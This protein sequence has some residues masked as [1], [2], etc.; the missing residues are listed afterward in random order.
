[1][2]TIEITETPEE[3]NSISILNKKEASL[4]QLA[5]DYADL[6]INGVSDKEGYKK[7][8]DA[9]IILKNTRIQIKKVA[10]D[11]REDAKNFQKKVIAKEN[12]LIGLIS[13]TEEA[14]EAE[15]KRIDSEKEAIKKE[16]ERKKA[17]KI[18]NRINSLA[19][20]NYA[21]DFSEV[22]TMSNEHFDSLLSHANKEFQKEQ[23]RIAEEKAE[24]ERKKAEQEELLAKQR[25]EIAE[26]KAKQEEIAREQADREAK[27]KKEQEEAQRK[28]EEQVREFNLI[29][30]EQ[31]AERDRIQAEKQAILDQKA[32]EESEK[33]RQ[34]EL[35]EARKQAAEEA[36]IE[37]ELKAEIDRQD[38]IRKAEEE[39]Q[40]AIELELSKDDKTKFHDMKVELGIVM[41]KFSFKSTKYKSLKVKVF[42]LVNQA[43]AVE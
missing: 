18:Q 33:Q 11:L 3:N 24:E 15:E 17:E 22:G 7:V 38:S 16:E 36:M 35:E 8:H 28:L 30:K 27:F 19:K 32:K 43:L 4:R 39:R 26:M 25:A 20:F 34:I 29:A 1:M 42:V 6:T 40:A 5:K 21:A 14:L 37:A 41:A 10:E 2:Q 13:P 12:E 31:Q 23:E 9:R